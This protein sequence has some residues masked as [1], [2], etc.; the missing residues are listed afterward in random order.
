MAISTP[1]TGGRA[2]NSL[3]EFTREVAGMVV[4]MWELRGQP[5]VSAIPPAVVGLNGLNPLYLV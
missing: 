5:R 4:A 2:R 3:K 1:N